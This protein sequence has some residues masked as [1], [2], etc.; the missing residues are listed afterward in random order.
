MLF[1]L[2]HIPHY[3]NVI[4][5]ENGSLFLIFYLKVDGRSP[6]FT[7]SMPGILPLS[8]YMSKQSPFIVNW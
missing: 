1:N 8:S 6:V 4:V 2:Y 3:R 7:F 5:Q